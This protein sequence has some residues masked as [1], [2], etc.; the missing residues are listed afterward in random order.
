M[1]FTCN[2]KC[3]WVLIFW[4]F[5]GELQ[6]WF[7]DWFID[8]SI[9]ERVSVSRLYSYECLILELFFFVI[10]C[11]LQNQFSL[12]QICWM[13]IIVNFVANWRRCSYRFIL[14]WM[15]LLKLQHHVL[16]SILARYLFHH[17]LILLII[18]WLPIRMLLVR[19]GIGKAM[20][21]KIIRA[22][23][24]LPYYRSI[25]NDMFNWKI[26]SI[27]P[28]KKEA[29]TYSLSTYIEQK[30]LIA[31]WMNWTKTKAI[32]LV[33]LMMKLHRSRLVEI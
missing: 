16:H 25:F 10:I 13:Y 19:C 1:W 26:Q 3:L 20:I 8:L 31:C 2:C 11:I 33:L 17:S 7:S 21:S 30:F 18:L 5:R 9:E 22:K 28:D 23:V 24:N 4:W 14:C 6:V 32:S 27:L 29:L 12:N 15:H